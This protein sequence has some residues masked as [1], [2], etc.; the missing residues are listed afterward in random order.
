MPRRSSPNSDVLAKSVTKGD[1]NTSP[2]QGYGGIYQLTVPFTPQGAGDLPAYWSPLRDRVLKTTPMRESMWASA[3]GI[4]TS[5]VA[6]SDWRLDGRKIKYWQD[7]LL[8]ADNN[9]SF[10]SF[11]EKQIRDYLLTD[12]GN[13]WETIRTNDARGARI[14]GIQHL[15]SWRIIRTGDPDIPAIYRDRRGE[16]HEMKDYQITSMVDEPDSD[17]IYFGTGHCL[18]GD[19]TVAMADGSHPFI[20]DLVRNKVKSNVMTLLPD[21]SLGSRPIV[22]WHTNPMGGRSWVVLRGEKSFARKQVSALRLRRDGLHLTCDHPVLTPSGWKPAGQIENGDEFVT[23]FP[24]PNH[25]QMEFLV[26]GILGDGSLNV[27]HNR[28]IRPRFSMGHSVEQKEW[29]DL[30]GSVLS[31]FGWSQRVKKQ[32]DGQ[33]TAQPSFIELWEQCYPKRKKNIPPEL[34]AEYISP[35]LLATWYLDDGWIRHREKNER[36]RNPIA[37]IGNSGAETDNTAGLVKVLRKAGYEC[38]AISSRGSEWRRDITFTVESSKKFFADI[39][40]YVPESMRYKL[41]LD[42]EP[43]DPELWN[44]GLAERFVDRA[45]V[46]KRTPSKTG[47]HSTVYCIDVAETHNFIS[48]STVV[49]NCAASRAW[50]AILKLSA[51]EL[52]VY[53]KVSGKKPSRIYLV[54]ANLNDKQ[55]QTAIDA[56]EERSNQKGYVMYMD[57]IMVP[58]L[59]PSANASVASIDLKGLP[60]NFDPEKERIQSMLTYAD[61]IGLDPVE[62]DPNLAARGRALGSGS[63]AQV[64][65][66]KQTGRGLITYYKKKQYLINETMLPD[67]VTFFFGNSDLV[68]NSRKATIFK[69][70]AEAARILVGPTNQALPIITPEQA[71]QILADMGDIS[72]EMVT[73]P[74]NGDESLRDIEKPSDLLI[75]EEKP[76]DS[77]LMLTEPPA[78]PTTGFNAPKQ[79]PAKTKQSFNQY[80]AEKAYNAKINQAEEWASQTMQNW[81]ILSESD[82]MELYESNTRGNGHATPQQPLALPVQLALPETA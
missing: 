11:E 44:L 38:R 10:V 66:D 65:D 5:R 42:S 49:H 82:L 30:K 61:S 78:P 35:L 70:H 14:I 57:A 37:F 23:S 7:L 8:S 68:D 62:L 64:L 60:E 41:P 45:V 48:A 17:D 53:E 19:M 20:K 58:I 26:G 63:Q 18:H 9:Q 51:L 21:G 40:P 27:G 31:E 2:Y 54:N 50:S 79:I 59:D 32:V 80:L 12:N 39:A 29:F 71:K 1:F 13:H 75:Q 34:V 22:G 73:M 24:A 77:A 55:L 67:R 16:W 47:V 6:G 81:M 33:T 3:I 52:Y 25:K 4:A 15:P 76:I 28:H 74:L 46:T 43:F 56:G 36:G 69:T 72:P